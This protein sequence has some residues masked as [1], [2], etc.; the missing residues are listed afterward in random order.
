MDITTF[1][2]AT[3]CLIEDHIGGQRRFHI[4]ASAED[5]AGSVIAE[6]SAFEA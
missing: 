1:M 3:Y 2:I 4:K 5:G 6:S